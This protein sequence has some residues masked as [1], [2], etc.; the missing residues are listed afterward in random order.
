MPH[1][2]LVYDGER[3]F[4]PHKQGSI[5][6]YQYS[7]VLNRQQA[8]VVS[9]THPVTHAPCL[10]ISKCYIAAVLIPHPFLWTRITFVL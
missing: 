1:S 7:F 9:R 4:L 2:S 10:I 8:G 6:P 5:G 3:D